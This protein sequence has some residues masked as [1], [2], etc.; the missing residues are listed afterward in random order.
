MA[1]PCKKGAR[2]ENWGRQSALRSQD[3]ALSLGQEGISCPHVTSL[4]YNPM[5]KLQLMGPKGARWLNCEPVA[6][7]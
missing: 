2:P 5:T 3:P 6:G 7:I 4:H 1:R